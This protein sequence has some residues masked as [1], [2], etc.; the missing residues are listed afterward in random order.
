MCS[1]DKEIHSIDLRQK[2]GADALIDLVESNSNATWVAFNALADLTCLLAFGVDIQRLKVIDLMAEGRMITLTH[3]NFLSNSSSLLNTLNV[4]GIETN[5][6][7]ALCKEIARDIILENETYT[8]DQW[9]TIVKYGETDVTPLPMLINRIW[10]IHVNEG[11]NIDT[12][13]MLMRGEYIK[14]LAQLD[15]SNKGFPLDVDL[16]NDIFN[17]KTNILKHFQY[18]VNRQYGDIYS[19]KGKDE[20]KFSYKAF[21]HWLELNDIDWKLTDKGWP[22]LQKDYFKEQLTYHPE[23]RNLY[24]VRKTLQSLS[25]T[26]IRSLMKDGHVKAGLFPFSQKT[27]RN[28]YKP[29]KGYM[30]NFTPWM[31]NL[32]RPPKGK[33]FVGLDWSQQEI[34]IAATLSND[35]NYKRIYNSNYGDVYIALAKMAGAVP[36]SAT[37]S[38]HPLERDI[39]KTIQLG[40][41]YGKGVKSLASDIYWLHKNNNQHDDLTEVEALELAQDIYQWHKS[42]FSDYWSWIDETI[43]SARALGFYRSIDGWVYFVDSSTRNTQLLNLPM[44]SNGAA[45]LRKAVINCSDL[46]NIE[47]V[48]TLHDAIYFTCDEKDVQQ[49]ITSVTDC[50]N[51][52]CKDLLGSDLVIRVD[53]SIYDSQGGYN[54]EKGQ[55]LLN[56]VKSALS[57]LSDAA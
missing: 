1:T 40:I 13:D 42:T 16:V 2:E 46:N 4:L 44:Q 55:Y 9:T 48:C 19:P 49:A 17:N 29:T 37:K 30:L 10:D 11:H 45:M 27:S 50:M 28:S 23:L 39:F 34:G 20:L 24:D 26:D 25:S 6:T 12:H 54:C 31:R 8:D 33:V 21:K 56:V 51:K 15:F 7:A 3:S 57:K 47:V 14:A 43:N 38:T 32:I 53:S 36:D 22:V 35:T 5:D 18:T 52:A 41:G